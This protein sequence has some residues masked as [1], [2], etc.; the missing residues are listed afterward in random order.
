MSSIYF[1]PTTSDNVFGIEY[2]CSIGSDRTDKYTEYLVDVNVLAKL[3]REEGSLKL[4]LCM[5]ASEFFSRHKRRC[6]L[7]NLEQ[8]FFSSERENKK[9]WLQ[10][11]QYYKI[12]VFRKL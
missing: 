6:D 3:A 12:A 10:V 2:H 4:E 5:S 7:E 9:D 1:V 11:A 8:M